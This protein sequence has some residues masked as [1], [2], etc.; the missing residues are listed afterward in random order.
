MVAMPQFRISDLKKETGM[1]FGKML[2]AWR[3][4]E[5][6]LQKD[7]AK[8]LDVGVS[9]VVRIE[10]GEKVSSNVIIKLIWYAFFDDQAKNR[11]MRPRRRGQKH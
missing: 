2:K 5:D 10:N 11:K 4:K 1:R 3:L 6:L 9:T 8:E 7:M